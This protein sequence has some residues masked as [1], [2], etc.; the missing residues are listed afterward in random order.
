[1]KCQIMPLSWHQALPKL[2]AVKL[3]GKVREP[4]SV[5]T[6]ELKGSFERK[7]ATS[8]TTLTIGNKMLKITL[9]SY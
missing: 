8:E 5:Q 1:M 4:M 3:T 2:S 6:A 7:A 9:K